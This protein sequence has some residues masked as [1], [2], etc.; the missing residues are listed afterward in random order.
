MKKCLK[1]TKNTK[2]HEKCLKRTKYTKNHKHTKNHSLVTCCFSDRVQTSFWPILG[3]FCS[4]THF[5][6]KKSKILKNEKK[7]QEIYYYYQY[8]ILLRV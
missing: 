5:L 3:H 4:F 1:R 2:N 7:S 6:P 8:V